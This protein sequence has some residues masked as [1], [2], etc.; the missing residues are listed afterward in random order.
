MCKYIVVESCFGEFHGVSTIEAPDIYEAYETTEREGQN[1]SQ[2]SIYDLQEARN[3][4]LKIM[5]EIRKNGKN[6]FAVRRTG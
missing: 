3:L 4:A 5:K 6:N 2:F 1:A